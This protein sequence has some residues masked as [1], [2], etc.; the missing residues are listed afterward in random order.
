MRA[1][2]LD[3]APAP[4]AAPVTQRVLAQ[5]RG[6]VSV[7]L[8]N[9]E[10]LLVA[11]VLPALVLVGLAG[12]HSPD[13]GPAR[14]IDVLTPGV[15]A[16]ALISSAFT[17]QAIQTGFDRRYGVLRLL[18]STPLG[19]TGLLAAKAVAT[20]V[21]VTLQVV[22]LGA[23]GLALGWHLHV[24]GL[25]PAVLLL[26]VGAAAFV[27]L[28]LLLAGLLRAEAVLAVANLVWV[29]MLAGSAVVVPASVM[30]APLE[31]LARY[32]PS[33]AIGAGLRTAFQHGRLAIGPLVVLVVWLAAAAAL[34]RRTFRWS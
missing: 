24:L 33:G 8:R 29:L 25:L 17:G 34:V 14:R 1:G 20:A 7:L 9:G 18:G 22:V 19:R 13:L 27:A 16:L 5:A 12:A 30:P 15:L 28:G 10:Q 26:A 4:D 21:V 32:L 31:H 6:E 3:L 2:R 23:L 11:V